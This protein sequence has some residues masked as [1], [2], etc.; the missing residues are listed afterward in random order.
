[1]ATEP[2]PEFLQ[3]QWFFPLFVG[4]WL[5]ITGLLAYMGGWAILASSFRAERETDGERFRFRSGSVGW[6]FFPVRYGNCLFV[7][8]NPEGLRLSILFPFRFLSP[9]LFIPWSKAESVEE[10]KIFFFRY[11]VLSIRDHWPR[12]T[13]RGSTGR[14]AKDAFEA[15]RA[16]HTRG[17]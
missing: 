1:M 2:V 9:P 10:K 16:K 15:F 13:L 11:Y 8:V 4:M 6:Q 17:R 14:H 5:G 7:T 12:I 3:P